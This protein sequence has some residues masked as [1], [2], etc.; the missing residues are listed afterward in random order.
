VPKLLIA[1]SDILIIRKL[2]T[3]INYIFIM[4]SLTSLF[5]KRAKNTQQSA[6][7]SLFAKEQSKK[8]EN[9]A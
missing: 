5:E 9:L 3:T 4:S 6:L 1:K 8:F 7:T 2:I